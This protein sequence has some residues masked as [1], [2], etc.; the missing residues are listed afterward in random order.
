[1]VPSSETPSGAPLA[2]ARPRILFVED[3]VLIRFML[4]EELRDVGYHVVEASDALEALS[5]L[6]T[7][8]PDLIITDVRMPGDIDGMD[9]LAMVR[10]SQPGLPVIIISGHLPEAVAL[11]NG[12]TQFLAKPF[13]PSEVVAAAGS[14]LGLT[15][16]S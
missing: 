15:N 4:C 9:L 3:E 14:V 2:S 12:A 6:S 5:F 1:M 13:L 7:M 11:Q 8:T 16:D 10:E